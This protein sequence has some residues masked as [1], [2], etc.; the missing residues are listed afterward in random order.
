MLVIETPE[1]F[2]SIHPSNS[3]RQVSRINRNVLNKVR[4]DAGQF[5]PSINLL[6]L[7]ISDDNRLPEAAEF[8]LKRMD[9]KRS[10]LPDRIKKLLNK[11][12]NRSM[13]F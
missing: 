6:H 11:N 8:N 12:P 7:L 9:V 5:L 13:L 10:I 3:P 4:V 2:S 1:L